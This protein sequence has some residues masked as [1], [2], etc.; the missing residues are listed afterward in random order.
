MGNKVRSNQTVD[1][2]HHHVRYK[3]RRRRKLDENEP[4]KDYSNVLLYCTIG[5]VIIILTCL[6]FKYGK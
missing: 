6:Y 5:A 4:P 3:K 1:Y 2:T